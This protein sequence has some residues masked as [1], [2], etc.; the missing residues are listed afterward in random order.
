M[1]RPV[2]VAVAKQLRLEQS[3]GEPASKQR[4]ERR[5]QLLRLT[6][7]YFNAHHG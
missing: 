2:T 6:F 7:I 1:N 5:D 4:L 3:V